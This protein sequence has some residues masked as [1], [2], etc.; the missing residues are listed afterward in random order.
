M[1]VTKQY[2]SGYFP[3]LL[4]ANLTKRNIHLNIYNKK[5]SQMTYTKILY[6]MNEH[7]SIIRVSTSL[8]RDVLLLL[9]TILYE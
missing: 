1:E 9:Y 7:G 4:S 5:T 3:S 8:I 6:I 2:F